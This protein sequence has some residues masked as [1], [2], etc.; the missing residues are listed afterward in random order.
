MNLPELIQQAG[1][2]GAG[3]A[4]FP[5]HV[6]A[7]SSVECVIANA[8]E[9]EP[10]L[11]KDSEVLE[12]H[13][14][15]IL[16]GL[17]LMME[18]TGA[19]QGVIGI[20]EKKHGPI[21]AITSLMDEER[22]RLCTLGDYYPTGDE[23]VLVYEATGRLIPPAGLPL[24][25]G[26]V[27]NNVETLLNIAN[28]VEGQPVTHKWLTVNGAVR[29]PVTMVVPVGLSFGEVLKAA[30]GASVSEFRVF[31]G[32]VMMGRVTGDL[33]EPVTKTTTGLIVLPTD[34]ILVRRM[35]Q[36][37]HAMHRIGR[38]ACDQCTYCTELCPRYLLGY[39]LEPH[40]VM[41]SLGF[42][43]AGADL[44]NR[45]GLLC[46]A[47]GLCTLYSCPELLFP[48][49]A[50]DKAKADWTAAGHPRP[51][52]KTPAKPHPL[53]AGRQAALKPLMARLDLKRFDRPAP[54]AEMDLSPERVSIPLRQ[55][56]GAPAVATVQAGDRVE[57]GQVIGEIPEGKL[58]ARVHASIAGTVRSVDDAIVIEQ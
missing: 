1:V 37:E 22:L 26:C 3:G 46:C 43:A 18:A 30:G 25:V 24:A 31:V 47:C 7:Q 15:R 38:S 17:K 20:K 36:T 40:K 44:W 54:F 58:G 56:L 49:E 32:G 28:A 6:K 13:A 16:A 35:T 50:C 10:L 29:K 14:A 42:T 2:V 53:R 11:H 8:A 52:F 4:G 33:S 41:R 5:A 55:H 19:A 45:K 39:E 57:A 23:Y 27:V 48:K 34:H 51:D 9:C 12:R 21:A